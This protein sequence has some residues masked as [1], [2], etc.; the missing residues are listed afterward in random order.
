MFARYRWLEAL[1]RWVIVYSLATLFI[2]L[3]VAPDGP[4]PLWFLWS[5]RVIT[6]VFTLEYLTRWVGSRSWWYPLRPMAL[7]DLLAVLPGYLILL[8]TPPSSVRLVR[9]L[10]LAR[11]LKLDRHGAA[12]TTLYRAYRRIG[13][14][15]RLT[16]LAG[17]T[18][19]LCAS[20]AVYECERVKQPEE[21]GR[22][23]DG[24]WYVLAT[25]TT[26][27]YGDKVPKTSEGRLVGAVVMLSGLVLFGTFVSL[28][29]GA[30]VEEI[31]RNR[32]KA[33]G[34]GLP[35]GLMDARAFDAAA[36]LAAIESGAIPPG[37]TPAH[38]D[39]LRLL[40]MACRAELELPA[41]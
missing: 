4:P 30:F 22:I 18:V 16:T 9:L 38:R 27:G 34:E 37:G 28:V 26:V 5:E 1:I 29:G 32:V 41:R 20:V 19:G 13:P 8:G 12:V 6:V 40:G 31:R 15:I 2:E 3:E 36:V 7:I 10:R 14:E 23:S 25:V 11:L 35:A 24:A 21:F 33:E 17:V 39:T